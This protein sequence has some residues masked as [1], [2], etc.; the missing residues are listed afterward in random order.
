M[1]KNSKT[2]RCSYRLTEKELERF[3]QRKCLSSRDLLRLI[4]LAKV[5][6]FLSLFLNYVHE[7][8]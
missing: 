5:L 3:L 2:T 8:F 6:P 7:R 4:V 1:K